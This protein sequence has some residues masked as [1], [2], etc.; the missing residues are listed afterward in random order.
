MASLLVGVAAVACISNRAYN[1]EPDEYVRSEEVPG[2]NVPVDFAIIEFDEF[3]VLWTRDQLDAAIDLVARAGAESDLGI[4]L[5]VHVHGWNQNADPDRE[6]GALETFRSSLVD[7]AENLVA[8][9][10]PA[11]QRVV[12]VF[13]GWRGATT[14]VPLFRES[15]FWA[16]KQVAERVASYHA[17]EAMFRLTRRAKEI[18]GSKVVISGHSMGGMIVGKT[19]GPAISSLLLAFGEQGFPMLADIVVL[20]NP[21][22]DALSS[23]QLVDF[24][25]RIGATAELRSKD[26]S[27]QPAPGPLMVSVTSEADWVT[28]VAYPIGQVVGAMGASTRDDHLEGEPSQWRLITRTNGHVDGLVSHRATVVDGEVVVERVPGSMN[29]TPFWILSVSR[30]ISAGHED[31][32][33]PYFMEL[34]ERLTKLNRVYDSDL[35]TWVRTRGF[36][37]DLPQE[38]R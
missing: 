30:E 20:Q 19:M 27:I 36:E 34:I 18:E 28:R 25:K 3:G 22:L 1:V 15:T 13:L 5:I 24:F 26:G 35:Q 37:A 33:G 29:D 10:P 2:S 21:A 12:G 6:D 31:V 9:G 23:Y 16:R 14:R 17:R 4:M 38:P 11:P 8:D 32:F 7:L